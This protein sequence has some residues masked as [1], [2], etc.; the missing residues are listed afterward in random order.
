MSSSYSLKQRFCGPVLGLLASLPCINS[1]A[2]ELGDELSVRGFLSQAYIHTSG[3]NYFGD[4]QDG[5]FDYRELGIN[6]YWQPTAN[7]SIA[8]QL[9]SRSAGNLSD[10]DPR[11]DYLLADYSFSRN[12]THWTGIRVGRYKTPY[13]FYN[14]TRDIPHARIGVI[15]PPS[16]Y[17]EQFRD[18]LLATDGVNLYAGAVN[19]WGTLEMDLFVGEA[20]GDIA[21]LEH[22]VFQSDAPGEFDTIEVWGGQ[23]R[24]EPIGGAA[25]FA[26]SVY[27]PD[28]QYVPGSPDLLTAGTVEST[29]YVASA[30][31]NAENW[32]VT[33]EYSEIDNKL[34]DFGP[35]FPSKD[36]TS[37][38]WFLQGEYHLS[39]EWSLMLR[40]EEQYLDT[41]D[42][43]GKRLYEPVFGIAHLAFAKGIAAGVRWTPAP[44]WLVRAEIHHTDGTLWLPKEDNKQILDREKVCNL[45]ALQL[46]YRF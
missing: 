21:E 33:A 35:A 31:Y 43:S 29:A 40:Y 36:G 19:D 16:I 7:L 8:G 12:A 23:I 39:P 22:Y 46:V 1:Y 27:Q 37:Q 32:S 26:F 13:G 2:L 18:S 15:A 6:A 44:D 38:A 4:S 24:Y 14:Q 28:I 25:R 5:S 9:L 45:F 3:N 10:G 41:D 30:Q 11:I 34:R 42:R 20:K 17:Y